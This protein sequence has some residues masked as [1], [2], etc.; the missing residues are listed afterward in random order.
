[1]KSSAELEAI[2]QKLKLEIGYSCA[3]GE[4]DIKVV[5]GM[6]TCG[7]AAGAREVV[8]TFMDEIEKNK[9][10]HVKVTQSGCIGK[11][12]KEPIVEITLPGKEKVTYINVNPD[13]AREIVASHIV[14]GK[15]V[16][17]YMAK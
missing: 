12:D 5:V 2:R 10:E 14:A 11:C 4:N 7:I 8:K 17:A 13:K 9:L 16:K 15:P 6:G 3:I 1:M